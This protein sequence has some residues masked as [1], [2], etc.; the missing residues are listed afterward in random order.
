MNPQNLVEMA[1]GI[2]AFFAAEPERADTVHG[3]ANH[4][5][6]FWEP[7]MQRQLRTAIAAGQANGLDPLVTEALTR[8]DTQRA[9]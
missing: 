5:D 7:R 9:A 4:L 3:I 8:L 6:K 2:A 1:N